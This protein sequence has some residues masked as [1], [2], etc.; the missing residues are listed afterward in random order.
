MPECAK[1]EG[2]RERSVPAKIA[3]YYPRTSCIRPLCP[4]EGEF[5]VRVNH[6]GS[7]PIIAETP[8]RFPR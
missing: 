6:L 8:E 5:G 1:G 7:G 3:G 4:M 2:A